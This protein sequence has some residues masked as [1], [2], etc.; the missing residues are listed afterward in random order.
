MLQA[1]SYQQLSTFS[2]ANTTQFSCC[3][4]GRVFW[5]CVYSEA[6]FNL[7]ADPVGPQG[8]AH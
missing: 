5:L 3:F 1:S 8:S 7:L 4:Y 6:Q 2:A